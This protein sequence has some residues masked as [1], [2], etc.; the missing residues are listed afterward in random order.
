MPLSRRDEKDRYRCQAATP[1]PTPFP[2]LYQENN[3]IPLPAA[4]A[5]TRAYSTRLVY[6][7]N[8]QAQRAINLMRRGLVSSLGEMSVDGDF[9]E[10]TI[11]PVGELLPSREGRDQ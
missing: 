11:S 3:K 1:L 10:L 2:R 7:P 4:P 8:K 9:F 5:P 6:I